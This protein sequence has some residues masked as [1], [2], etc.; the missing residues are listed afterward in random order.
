MTEQEEFEFR[1]RLEQEQGAPQIAAPAAPQAATQ[2]ERSLSDRAGD[3]WDMSTRALKTSLIDPAL[4]L[5]AGVMRGAGSLGSFYLAPYDIAKD[6]MAGKGLSLESNMKRR[7][8]IDGG[9]EALGADTD[10][11]TYGAGKLVGEIAGTAGVGPMLAGGAKVAG[12]SPAI[13]SG[14]Q[15]GGLNVA[16]RTGL[17]GLLTRAGT[18]AATGALAAGMVNPEDADVGAM[19][20]GALPV[21]AKGG[22]AVGKAATSGVKSL[23]EPL[24]QR[25]QEKIVGRALR[26]FAGDQVD[27]AIRNLQQSREL[28][29][30]SLPTVGEASGVPSLAALQRASVNVSPEAANAMEARAVANNQARV[31]VLERLSGSKGAREAA[32]TARDEAAA[33]A[34]GAAR[35]QDEARRMAAAQALQEERKQIAEEASKWTGLGS[36]ANA[37]KPSAPS[38]SAITPSKE[39][40][41]LAKRPTMKRIIVGA[42]RLAKD[43]GEQIGN[44]LESID[45]LHYI[46]LAVDDALSGTPAN[47]LARNQKAAVMDIK[48]RL[49]AEMDKVSPAYGEARRAFAEASKPINQMDIVEELKGSIAP[50]TGKLRAAQYASKLSD[51]TAARAT[52]FKGATLKNTLSPEQ[53][54]QLTA[55]RDDL[56]RA[57]F[58]ANAGRAAGTNTVQNLSYGYM[59]N[60][61]GVPNFLRNMPAGQVVGGLLGRGADAIYGKAN[62]EIAGLLAETMLSPQ[63]A[64]RLMMIRDGANPALIEAARKGLL[65]TSKAAPVMAAD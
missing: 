59:L 12:A 46:K 7:E 4:N 23:V 30:G 62:K 48:D 53:L 60:Q 63:E 32:E 28:V 19:V 38:A 49:I 1:L 3:L 14:L 35:A 8:G 34:Y 45:G 44:P 17:G 37:P 22:A 65:G 29:P 11:A 5:Q 25:G 51:D 6:A 26:E 2:P 43:K 55:I 52:G 33:A 61:F 9:L 18:G 31:D 50:L 10:S 40:L 39:L 42:K 36:L 15:S 20:G 57:D 41:E 13:V 58:A 27:D 47:A 16:G 24:Y 21:L 64:A 56:A 54:A